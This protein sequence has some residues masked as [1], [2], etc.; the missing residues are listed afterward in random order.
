MPV[1]NPA[2][3]ERNFRPTSTEFVSAL[4]CLHRIESRDCSSGVVSADPIVG[5]GVAVAP[6]GAVDV[7]VG[8]TV[9]GVVEVAVGVMVGGE[10]EE[11]RVGKECGVG[12]GVAVTEEVLFVNTTSTE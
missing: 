7:G 12:V 11:R 9:G 3:S 8:V 1:T 2:T 5:D 4:V 6:G 10:I